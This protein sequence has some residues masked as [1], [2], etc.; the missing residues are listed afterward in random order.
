MGCGVLVVGEQSGNPKLIR[1]SAPRTVVGRTGKHVVRLPDKS[2]SREHAIIERVRGSW[3]VRDCE[4]RNGT[5]VNGIAVTRRV[6]RD[7]DQLRFG[8]VHV[9][10]HEIEDE[11]PDATTVDWGEPGDPITLDSDTPFTATS[12]L[13][14]PEFTGDQDVRAVNAWQI[15][16]TFSSC[17]P[18][19]EETVLRMIAEDLAGIRDVRRVVMY[20]SPSVLQRNAKWIKA[21][22][23]HSRS[24]VL[25]PEER[26][27]EV[28]E[29]GFSQPGGLMSAVQ[30]IE[31]S[32]PAA[33]VAIRN[34]SGPAGSLYVES[35]DLL[36]SDVL[37]AILAAGEAIG[38]GLRLR[39]DAST[40]TQAGVSFGEG[41]E[42]IGNSQV[43]QKCVRMATRAAASDSTVLVRGESGT[44]KELLARLV[45]SESHR[46]AAA[47]VPVH[48]SA[49]EETL[50]GSTLFGHEKGA[51][52]GAVGTKKGLF[53]EADGGTIFLDEIGELT[54]AM[55]VKL[56][57]VLQ[58]GEF[59]RIG[60]NRPMHTDVRVIAATNRDLEAAVK[61]GSFR[62]DLYYRLK[63]IQISLPPLRKRREDIPE[64]VLHFVH[65]LRTTV[66][67]P[68]SE[69]S[70]DALAA[71]NRYDWPGNVRELRNVVERSLVLAEGK[72][73]TID[74]LPVEI[75]GNTDVG[76]AGGFQALDAYEGTLDE[77]ERRFIKAT[78][79]RC[80]GNKRLAAQQLGIS[81]STL[82]E[83]LK[84]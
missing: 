4:S 10:F 1:L 61:E 69:V 32:E 76:S 50:L 82:Y 19:S 7:G 41:V 18:G 51:F 14:V 71:M 43:L 47:F 22:E 3:V 5:R 25:F 54:Q 49:I 59:M 74:D 72:E 35:D 68:V 8:Q 28:A 15:V 45:Y 79:K 53:E 13:T 58:E 21:G 80:D 56:L 12:C 52:T 60:G 62:E 16:R 17:E 2:V 63:V 81:R 38:L 44:G 77:M 36:P 23:A 73:L 11:E 70:G 78:L 20:I 27:I 46:A 84:G 30:P 39:S 40:T 37:Q 55:Q 57:R 33:C 29:S 48:S 66:A 42:I 67:T 75:T 64:L 24:G 31:A 34:G 83:K 65:T 6:L 26:I 9:T